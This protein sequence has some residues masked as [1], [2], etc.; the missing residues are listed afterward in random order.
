MALTQEDYLDG[1]NAN[2]QRDALIKALIAVANNCIHYLKDRCWA[3]CKAIE[4][5]PNADRGELGGD[6]G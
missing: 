1:E 5:C 3:K 2:K 4:Y 6:L